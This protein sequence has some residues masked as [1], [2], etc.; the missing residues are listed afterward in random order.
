MGYRIAWVWVGVLLTLS[1][2]AFAGRLW[3][4]DFEA[5]QESAKTSNRYVLLDF[6]GSDWCGWCIK[7]DDEVFSQKAFKDYAGQELVCVLLD[8]PRRKSISKKLKTQN[9][10]LA[11]KY[12]IRGYPSVVLL[13]PD[14]KLVTRTG[15]QAG[16]AKNYIE[17]LKNSI[18]PHR[19]NNKVP[20]ATQTTGGSKSA[21]APLRSMR[22]RPLAKSESRKVRNWTSKSG[23]SVTASVLEEKGVHVI[24]QPEEGDPVTILTRKLSDTDIAYLAELRKTEAATPDATK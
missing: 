16:G 4:T 18:D 3:L 15:Y 1:T 6:T 13:S 23:N 14:G 7:L 20:E 12:S 10:E 24:L 5:A 2:P 21:R 8:F 9:A 19:E 11:K 17:H 22:P